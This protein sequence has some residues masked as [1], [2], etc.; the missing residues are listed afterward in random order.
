MKISAVVCE[1][2]PFHNGHKYQIE[3]AKKQLGCDAVVGIMSGN[4]VQRGTPAIFDKKIRAKAAIENGMDLVL[5]LPTVLTLQSAER[6]A[7]NAV[8]TLNALGCV[9]TLF[10]GAECPD[11]DALMSIAE[12]LANEDFYYKRALKSHLDKGLSFAVSRSNAVKDVIGSASA[13]ILSTPNNI[14]AV[15]Y[16]K[17]I[18]KAK[19]SIKPY[20]IH[21][22]AVEHNSDTP[23]DG[24]ASATAIR[25]YMEYGENY[26]EY[27]PENLYE[28][29]KETEVYSEVNAQ[30]AMLANLCLMPIEKL[31]QIADVSEGLEYSLKR[32]AF[33]ANTLD[34]LLENVK[35]KR[36]AYSRLKRIVLNAYLGI[37]KEDAEIAPQYIKILDFN[38]VGRAVLNMSKKTATLPLAKNGAQVKAYPDALK[39][40]E[41][42]LAIDR[43]YDLF[44]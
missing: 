23:K 21:R 27:V 34:E 15:E 18:I 25:N 30:K 19:S 43:I 1:Y 7:K 8:G 9:D 10:F 5:E 32:T 35:S 33:T 13:E 26:D 14:L 3:T 12:V 36:Y 28:K 40:W 24:Y 44:R 16:C 17:A 38:D 20:A 11:T 41:R 42:E 39:L 6:Y 29:Y 37:T 2:N 4:Y 31:A 22:K